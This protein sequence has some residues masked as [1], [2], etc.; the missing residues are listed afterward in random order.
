MSLLKAKKF[1]ENEELYKERVFHGSL[2]GFI[3]NETDMIISSGIKTFKYLPY[4]KIEDSVP[5]I[6]RRLYEKYSNN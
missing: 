4:G 5:Y 1:K 2:Y 6:V 3:N